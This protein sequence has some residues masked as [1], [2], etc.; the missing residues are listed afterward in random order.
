MIR[1]F[2]ILLFFIL[3]PLRLTYSQDT[4]HLSVNYSLNKNTYSSDETITVS[5]KV[6][7]NS[8]YHINSNKTNDPDL[9]TTSVSVKSGDFKSVGISYPK[10]KLYKF[11][12]S[13]SEVR[14]FDG[15][16]TIRCKVKPK[17]ELTDGKYTIPLQLYYQAC[18]DKMCFPPKTVDIDVPV[19][20]KNEVVE[21]DETEK[22][23]TSKVETTKVDT[24]K[25]D[26]SKVDTTKTIDSSQTSVDKSDSLLTENLRTDAPTTDEA[27]V[28]NFIQEKGLLVGLIFI[29]LG[30]LALNL[31]PCI[32]PLIPITI[33]FFGAQGSGSKAQ[34]IFMGIF[35]ALG[36]SITYSTLGLVAALTGSLLGTALQNPLVIL[37]IALILIVLG[38][39][40]FGAFEIR[41]PQKLAQAGGKSRSGFVGSLLMG[42]MVGL[43]A[44]PCIGPF[45][46][47]LLVYVGHVGNPFYGFL[48]FFV[49]SMGLGF[50]YIFLAA[51]SSALSKL[52]KS[53]EWMEGVKVIFGLI[54]FGMA[55]NIMSPVIP[56][57][58]YDCLFPLYIILSGAYLILI[59]KKGSVS[60][61]FTKIKYIIAIVA[62]IF[63]T[64][65]L[66][67]AESTEEVQW[68]VLNSVEEMETSINNEK[69]PVMIDFYADWCI[70]CKE[71]DKYTYTDKGIIDLSKSLNNIKIDLTK[72]NEAITNKYNI[73]GLPV[74]IFMNSKGE[75]IKEL[76]VTGFL[77]PEEF[78]NKINSLL[79]SEN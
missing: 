66:K 7:I 42:L 13:E 74:V 22:T 71:L 39:S 45:V 24:L 46:L 37:F 6:S 32:Y 14:V 38:T 8:P 62:V 77:N 75:E 29:F 61:V 73:K 31:T 70:Q 5:L 16:V 1:R 11:E 43:I 26:T 41:V 49:L 35:Y 28:S 56:S 30:G 51:S 12:F 60:P 23:D 57:E 55:I 3:I 68:K 9:I 4:K 50:P 34:S 47:S 18:D 21:E 69:L 72:E 19:N 52:P 44:A 10:D 63:G 25:T 15:N 59:S 33:S 2:F 67:P 76:R 48:L 53:G 65:N 36:M 40:M 58:I 54:L 78:S 17:K 79:E 20:I 27:E 64:W